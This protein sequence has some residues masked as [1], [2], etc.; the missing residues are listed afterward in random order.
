[1]I[2]WNAAIFALVISGA[3][4]AGCSGKAALPAKI[5]MNPKPAGTA[6]H[7][8]PGTF[9]KPS[10]RESAWSTFSD[11]D[12]GVAF[13]YPR[14]FALVELSDVKEGASQDNSGARSPEELQS[15][16]PGGVLV[17][18][19]MVP[20]DAYPNTS[21]AGGSLQFAVNRYLTAGTCRQ[22][23]ISRIGDSNSRTGTA[24][25]QGVE[26]AWADNDEGDADTEFF[27]RDYAGFTNETCYEFFLRAGV[28]S[29]PGGSRAPDDQKILGHLEKI[30]SS[31]QFEWKPVSSL[32]APPS[33]QLPRRKQ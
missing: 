21:F 8:Q 12:L 11:P 6:P 27:E 33:G 28:S 14:N 24:I 17:A 13:R 9:A 5:E 25:I 22:N 26:F 29:D 1:M 31:L 2:R 20:D 23:L 3:G 19:L 15:E 4:M 32:D 30:V 10:S 7:L 16:E 18:T